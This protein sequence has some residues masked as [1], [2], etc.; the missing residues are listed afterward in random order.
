MFSCVGFFYGRRD[1][2]ETEAERV[3]V[4]TAWRSGREGLGRYLESSG[5]WR[6]DDWAARIKALSKVIVAVVVE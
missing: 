6:S 1:G 5:R 3:C 2:V 4:C